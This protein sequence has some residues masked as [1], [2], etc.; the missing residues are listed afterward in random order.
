MRLLR[1]YLKDEVPT[2]N[3]NNI[4]LKYIGRRHELPLEVQE[5]M[6]WA[7]ED[8]SQN[9]GM[10]LTLALN[11]CARTEMVDAFKSIL[12]AAANNGGANS[13]S[14]GGASGAAG[15]GASQQQ[16]ARGQFASPTSPVL[17][18]QLRRVWVLGA[19]GKP[20]P[21]RI[22]I[23]LTDGASTEVVE[24]DLKEGDVVITVQNITAAS[25]A[26]NGNTQ[27]APPGFGGAPRMG[28]GGARGGGR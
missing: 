7:A 2:L 11:Y 3:R 12:S 4:R 20:Q 13:A 27:S 25:K 21:R 19:D 28:G 6:A 24:G 5:R 10:V 15:D 1:K 14:N 9:T 26:Q 22:K 17:P 16:G 8:T 18:G 23:G